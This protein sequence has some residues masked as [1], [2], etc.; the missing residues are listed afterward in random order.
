MFDLLKR[1]LTPQTNAFWKRP[2][3]PAWRDL[4]AL[5]LLVPGIAATAGAIAYAVQGFAAGQGGALPAQWVSLAVR[6]G[7][8]ALA[9]GAEG[10]TLSAMVEIARKR[11]ANKSN[12]WDTFNVV[13]SL[14][15]TIV[16]RLMALQINQGPGYVRVLVIASAL[17]AYALM[18]ELGMYLTIRDQAMEMY[19]LARMWFDKGNIHNAILCLSGENVLPPREE[20]PPATPPRVLEDVAMLKESL[21][22][23]QAQFTQLQQREAQTTISVRQRAILQVYSADPR[24]SIK[25]AAMASACSR[26]TVEKELTALET[27]RLISRDGGGEVR[28][29]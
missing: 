24:A 20:P 9:I 5:S 2:P 21:A 29:L 3:S 25:S 6:W 26:P 14:I 22:T 8:V 1:A 7:G 13:V 10:G 11:A 27:A 17:D 12:W 19:L 16:A 23:L 28:V 4:R 15:A 18:S